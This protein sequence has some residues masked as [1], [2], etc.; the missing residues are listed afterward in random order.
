MVISKTKIEKSKSK[1]FQF[2]ISKTKIEKRMKKKTNLELVRT[3]IKLKKT[4]P[5]VAKLLA[6][7]VK[8]W[9]KINLEKIDEEVKEGVTVLVPGKVLSSGMLTKKVKVLAWSVS[10]KALE[11]I[12]KSGSEFVLISEEIK[13]NP[14]LGGIIILR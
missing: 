4:N 9:A 13:K 8:K 10:K 7:P 11:K 6:M 2:S 12:K 14:K 1:N 5:E 3:I